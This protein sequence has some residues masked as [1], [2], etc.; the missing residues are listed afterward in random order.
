[1]LM[2]SEFG[3]FFLIG[4]AMLLFCFDFEGADSSDDRDSL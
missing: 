1:M 4:F 3:G 2:F